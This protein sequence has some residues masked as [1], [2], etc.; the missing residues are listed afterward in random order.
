MT[1]YVYLP[2]YFENVF[3]ESASEAGVSMIPLMLGLPVGAIISGALVRCVGGGGAAHL[4]QAGLF[5]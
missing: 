3:R 1:Q 2:I 4:R 5:S